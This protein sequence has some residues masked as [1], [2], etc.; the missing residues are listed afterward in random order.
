MDLGFYE[1]VV[2]PSR[3]GKNLLLK[4]ITVAVYIIAAAIWIIT[5]VAAERSLAVIVLALLAASV[6][7]YVILSR[8]SFD[9]EYAI[10]DT[11][12]TL[13]KIYGKSRRKEVF[14][15]GA[16]NI[17]YIAPKTEDNLK[18]C[19]E[20]KPKSQYDIYSHRSEGKLWLIVFETAKEERFVFVFE[21]EDYALKLLKTLKPSAMY[22]K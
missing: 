10:S 16:E 13:A 22:F 3:K 1:K 7:F 17:L 15:I 11:S 19:E 21:P 20:F 4:I 12:V 2:K 6:I 18:K 5:S 8:A 14:D 9:Y